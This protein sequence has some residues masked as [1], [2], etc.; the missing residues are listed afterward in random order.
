[1]DAGAEPNRLDK[2]DDEHGD[3]REHW[4]K[5]EQSCHPILLAAERKGCF[6]YSIIA[7]LLKGGAT[8]PSTR[9]G[10]I[11]PA[12]RM[13][14]CR[15]IM[16]HRRPIP[17]S[18]G[19]TSRQPRDHGY[20]SEVLPLE[21]ARRLFNGGMRVLLTEMFKRLPQQRADRREFQTL[22]TAAST[23][24]DR[25]SVKLLLKHGAPVNH[26]GQNTVFDTPLGCAALY[27]HIHIMKELLNAGADVECQGFVDCPQDAMIKAIMGGHTTAVQ[28]LVQSGAQRVRA[29]GRSF[30]LVAARARNTQMVDCLLQ[31]KFSL[32]GGSDA[33]LVA[34]ANGDTD[35]VSRLLSAGIDLNTPGKINLNT[36]S[37]VGSECTPLYQASRRGHLAIVQEL[38]KHGADPIRELK[39]VSVFPSLLLRI[40][41]ISKL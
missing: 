2:D 3:S 17:L 35:I 7:K 29:Q 37:K 20:K 40:R 6:S 38:L 4:S 24:G 41:D 18:Y 23:A 32:D 34:C 33:L 30:L 39:K 1:M 36:P 13:A 16:W 22:L 5:G 21:V 28:L 8:L 9:Q 31:L 12:L 25:V 27:G 10:Q 11:H 14:L 19:S 26:S 15:P